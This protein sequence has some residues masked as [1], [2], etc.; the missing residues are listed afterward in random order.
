[1]NEIP[2][3]ERGRAGANRTVAPAVQGAM[4]LHDLRLAL[5]SLVRRPAFALTAV[6]LLAL[7]TGANGVVLSVAR[8]VLVR[9]LPFAAPDRLVAVWPGQY[10]SNE[11]IGLWR[12]RASSLSEQSRGSPPGG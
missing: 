5:R 8:G 7:G 9:P 12:D 3:L 4:L 2:S 1:M 6:L 11:E 10:V